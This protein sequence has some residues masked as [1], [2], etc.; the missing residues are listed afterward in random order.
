MLGATGPI[1]RK[2]YRLQQ[3]SPFLS[4]PDSMGPLGVG[5]DMKGQGG[6]KDNRRKAKL[7]KLS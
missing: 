2:H 5:T 1:L 4:V 6:L 3:F 7:G